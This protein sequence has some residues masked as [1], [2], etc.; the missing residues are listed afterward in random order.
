MLCSSIHIMR[1]VSLKDGIHFAL[2]RTFV[3]DSRSA[4]GDVNIV[5]HAHADHMPRKTT[6][7]VVCS[8]LTA[9]LVEARSGNTVEFSDNHDTVELLPSG[10]IVGSR[11]ALIEDNGRRYLY[12]GDVSTRDRCY[13]EG[14]EP[15]AADELIIE[16]TYGVPAYTFPDQKELE[17]EIQDWI[18]DNS[19]S[20]LFLF[21]YSLGRAQKL[22]W[23]V[24]QA[25]NR[26]IVAHG[27]IHKMNTVI[28]EV[29]DLSFDAVPYAENKELVRNGEAILVL[30]PHLARQEWVTDLAFKTGAK[31]AGFSGWAVNGYGMRGG[32]DA[33]FPLSD[34]CDFEELVELVKAVDPE[35]VYTQHG[36]DEAF[37]SFLRN[38]Y[39]FDARPLKSTQSSLTDF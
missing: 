19:G 29:G 30:P 20:P 5:T 26:P 7:N 18:V 23:L 34:H 8:E 4:L 10:H 33:T 12:T 15:V 21:G 22:Q 32:Y 38:D 2:S 37:A 14:F 17:A 28:E 25:T 27:A 35:K 16:S 39:G 11:A 1:T 36:F 24:Q 3:A 31:K 9:R 6:D 13:M